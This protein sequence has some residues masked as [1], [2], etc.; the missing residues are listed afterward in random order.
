MN[1][2]FTRSGGGIGVS[3]VRNP[4]GASD[5]ARSEYSYDDLPGGTDRHELNPL[6][7]FA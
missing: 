6:L 2:L 3:F 4:M 1:N 5:L 7:H